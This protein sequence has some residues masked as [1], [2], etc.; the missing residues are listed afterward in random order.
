MP[1][2]PE[3]PPG[4]L[5]VAEYFKIIARFLISVA[6]SAAACKE[7]WHRRPRQLT[8]T[9]DT[10]GYPSY[11]NFNYLPDFTA[12]HLL[13][14]AFPI[15]TLII[16]STLAWL[17]PLRRAP[18]ARKRRTTARM[19]DFPAEPSEDDPLALGDVVSAGVRIMLPAAVVALAVSARSTSSHQTFTTDGLL[20]GV[21]YVVLTAVLAAAV[22]LLR[23][24]RP[25]RAAATVN[26]IAGPTVAIGS[27]WVISQNTVVVVAGHSV[28]HWPWLPGW[29]AA[30]GVLACVAWA[31]LRLRGGRAPAAVE[32]RLLAVIVGSC[33]V[34]IFTSGLPGQQ[35]GLQGYD[36][37]MGLVGA[38]LLSLGYFPWRDFMFIHGLWSDA[39]Q[40]AIGFAQFGATRWG[41]LAGT[42]VVVQ[43]ATFVILY[44]FAVWLARGNGWF[45]ASLAVLILAFAGRGVVNPRFILIPVVL[46]LLGEALRRESVLWC[47]GFMLALLVE[48]ILVPESSYLAISSL[49]VVVAADLT[50][51]D[52]GRG[53]WRSL[54]RTLSCTAAGL[55]LLAAWAAFLAA[56]HA[57]TAWIEYYRLFIPDHAAEG[58]RPLVSTHIALVEYGVALALVVATFWAAAARVRGGRSWSVRDWVMVAAAGFVALYGEE[59]TAR[60]VTSRLL[61]VV[62][63]SVPLGLLWLEQIL[64][65]ADDWLR[66]MAI[67]VSG[68][69]ALRRRLV[70][71]NPLTAVL[72]AALVA[73]ALLGQSVPVL[74]A[75]KSLPSREHATAAAEPTIPGLGYAVPGAVNTTLLRDLTAAL[76]ANGGPNA[77]VFDMTNS[78][79]YIYF[80]L[81]RRPAS[82]FVHVSMAMTPYGQ[83][84]LIADLR[85]SAPPVVIFNSTL[86]GHGIYGMGLSSWDGL[87]N[88]IRHYE[89]SDYILHHYRPFLVVDGVL[90]LLRDGLRPHIPHIAGQ[91]MTTNLWFADGAC[92][93]GYTPNFLTSRPAGRT[94]DVPVSS[95]GLRRTVSLN[96]WVIGHSGHQPVSHF[97]VASGRTVLRLSWPSSRG[98]G[99]VILG[100]AVDVAVHAPITVYVVTADGSL[101]PVIG[102]PG[103]LRAGVLKLPDG[104]RARIAAPIAGK[105]SISSTPAWR[106]EEARLPA[107]LRLADF[108][109]LTLRA[110]RVIGYS[111]L[112]VSD[113]PSPASY[114]QILAG[115]VPFGGRSVGLRVG[116]CMDWYGYQSR[117]L[118]ILQ[119][120]GAP[121]TELQLSG[122]A[123]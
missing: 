116:S 96:G 34:F 36:D 89:V 63:A 1:T 83:E 90:L 60:L 62:A 57:L 32:G 23:H 94:V 72:T 11:H 49:A 115:V 55:V 15:G 87:G 18:S 14:Y 121:I 24:V 93:W 21:A 6:V 51:W 13:I 123:S 118:F 52:T 114:Y 73:V 12:Y 100:A 111:Q 113:E 120:G 97:A 56:H 78:L 85:R 40:T 82:A 68:A 69:S 106:E 112:I 76:N 37:S 42:D 35:G 110:H 107:G 4:R 17:W 44:L 20:A 103:T 75:A 122:V 64:A 3:L 45:L 102:E 31:L 39:L 81:A 117:E 86:Y 54:R 58:A 80:L 22:T 105:V 19:L 71:R 59:A 29:L 67:R 53:A 48:I 98:H 7:Y 27:L 26:A 66:A 9:T 84:Q 65:T 108:D 70:A 88:D 46:M 16:Y 25:R 104:R 99:R 33:A 8:G 101:H 61:F 28:Q 77:P 50:H 119:T 92:D 79:G 95:L 109:L 2:R 91:A 38:R 10:L 47:A 43:P 5:P 41:G 30:A 74:A